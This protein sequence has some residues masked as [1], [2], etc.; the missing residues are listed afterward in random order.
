MAERCGN[1]AAVAAD[2]VPTRPRT[3]RRP[4]RR[5]E[6]RHR[7]SQVAVG[8]PR[9]PAG[10]GP[11]VRAIAPAALDAHRHGRP[12]APGRTAPSP[13][14]PRPDGARAGETTD[15][16]WEGSAPAIGPIRGRPMPG[17]MPPHP[18][19]VL[20]AWSSQIALARPIWSAVNTALSASAASCRCCAGLGPSPRSWRWAWSIA[21]KRHRRSAARMSGTMARSAAVKARHCGC[22]S[23]VIARKISSPG[24]P[25][26]QMELAHRRR[27][28]AH[29][30]LMVGTC[31]SPGACCATAAAA[32]DRQPTP[33]TAAGHE[34]PTARGEFPS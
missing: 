8:D 27:F 16:S 24:E 11:M 9:T 25:L 18:R 5:V 21:G 22:C 13:A 10:A 29:G 20:A 28:H 34:H 14:I 19:P 12:P 30:V 33:T 3:M 2:V 7:A 15:W 23:G 1:S 4:R 32:S 26:R 17:T 6:F 31:A